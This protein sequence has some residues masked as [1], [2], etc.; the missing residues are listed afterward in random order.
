[1]APPHSQGAGNRASMHRPACPASS[2]L[3]HSSSDSRISATKSQFPGTENAGEHSRSLLS[4]NA[5]P[6]PINQSKHVRPG[7]CLIPES[8]AIVWPSIVHHW[9]SMSLSETPLNHSA[10]VAILQL[11]Q[12][13]LP[14]HPQSPTDQPACEGTRRYPDA[15]CSG[16]PA[17]SLFQNLP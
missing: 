13:R 9:A 15:P 1:M 14:A 5:S 16:V 3:P 6:S 7:V 2:G 12:P 10:Q 4:L 11:V 17:R 8:T